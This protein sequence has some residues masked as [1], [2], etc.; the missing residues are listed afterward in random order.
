MAKV[1]A[2]AT[3]KANSA[4]PTASAEGSTP[5]K[6]G[7]PPGRIMPRGKGDRRRPF[8]QFK[9]LVRGGQTEQ[10]A[11]AAN[12]APYVKK[13]DLSAVTDPCDDFIGTTDVLE[14][15]FAGCHTGTFP[16]PY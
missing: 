10:A 4:T 7:T 11:K 3:K 8:P 1:V 5:P 13:Q 16:D 9:R 15:W 2:D 12:R 6:V 14:V